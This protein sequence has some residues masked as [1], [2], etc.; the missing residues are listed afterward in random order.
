MSRVTDGSHIEV[1]EDFT[2][3]TAFF[4]SERKCFK[5]LSLFQ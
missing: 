2:E 5:G 1:F 3:I 4:F